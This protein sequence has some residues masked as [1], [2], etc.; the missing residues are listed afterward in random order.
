MNQPKNDFRVEVDR[1]SPGIAVV[2]VIGDADLYSAPE[3][4]ERLTAILEEEDVAHVVVD[5]SD[6]TFVDSMTLGVLIG[7]M[8]RSRANGGRLELVVPS[9]E[10]RRIFEITKLDPIFELHL[11]R[12][13]ALE[14]DDGRSG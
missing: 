6:T 8:K 14:T 11:D 13:Q 9:L 1:P 12:D 4:R 3:L 5:L 10:I 7:A 2:A